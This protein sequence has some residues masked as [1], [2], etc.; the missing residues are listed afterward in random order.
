[1]PHCGS[2]M[3]ALLEAHLAAQRLSVHEAAVSP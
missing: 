3:E 1:M 2:K